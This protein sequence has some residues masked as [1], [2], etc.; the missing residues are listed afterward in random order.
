MF[1]LE[2]IHKVP[3]SR[4]GTVYNTFEA[5]VPPFRLSASIKFQI[6]SFVQLT[7][8]LK[9]LCHPSVVPPFRCATLPLECI[10]KVPDSRFGTVYNTF[11]AVVPP[12]RLSASIKFQIVGLV[13]FTILLKR[14]CHPFARL[15]DLGSP[16]ISHWFHPSLKSGSA[17][18]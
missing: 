18:V 15:E 11:E 14:L 17:W 3:D 1:E 4:V 10:R 9:P 7:I 5:V 2:C 6:V 8:L 13:Q 16:Q 12:F